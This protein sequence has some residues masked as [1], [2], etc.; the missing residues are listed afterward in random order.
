MEVFSVP[1]LTSFEGKLIKVDESFKSLL[2]NVSLSDDYFSDSEFTLNV[3]VGLDYYD[4]FI[5]SCPREIARG[6]F[7]TESKFGTILSGQVNHSRMGEDKQ[8]LILMLSFEEGEENLIEK[9]W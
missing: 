3:I 7:T 4:R 2:K 9:L 1:I 6:I 8:E 5:G